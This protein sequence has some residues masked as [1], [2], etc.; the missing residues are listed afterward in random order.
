M[1]EI[2]RYEPPG[3]A[4]E[5]TGERWTSAAHGQIEIEH[6]H[7]Y[8]LARDWCRG[9]DVLDIA[10]GEGYGTALLAQV[11]RHAVGVEIDRP[12]LSHA[13]AQYRRPNLRYVAGD[14]CRLP[15]AAA[16]VDIAVSFETLEHLG[17]QEAFLAEI[18]R[19][20][21]PGGILLI[22]T[23]DRDVYSP[24]GS[25]PNV[26]H[27][28]ELSREEFAALLFR[29]FPHV[30]ICPQ[31]ALVGSAILPPDA[32]SPA[33]PPITY[34]RRGERH[35]ERSEGLPRALYLLAYASDRPIA[36][37]PGPSLYIH[38]L[39]IDHGAVELNGAGAESARSRLAD[40][41][42][43]RDAAAHA[44]E[45]ARTELA[46]TAAEAARL[47]VA[48]SH[49]EEEMWQR[50]GAAETMRAE[51]DRLHQLLAETEYQ[52]RHGAHEAAR[53]RAEIAELRHELEQAADAAEAG[54]AEMRAA[55]TAL[56]AARQVGRT[57][58]EALAASLPAAGPAAARR[59]WRQWLAQRW[60]RPRGI[61]AG[62]P[63]TL[64]PAR[65]GEVAPARL[66]R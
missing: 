57:A 24:L 43:E 64:P 42:R 58:L 54:A 38:S 19:V 29:H 66:S 52:L 9:K 48:L 36:A 25:S 2:F 39:D 30:A 22:S 32:G 20:L 37:P 23:P 17:E 11:A 3:T 31:R 50:A 59:G 13:A 51:I 10:C 53:L 34:E 49:A 35:L 46:E 60:S 61:A 6:L 28:R 33:G 1:G 12:T 44:A 55:E 21:R 41:V 8:I 7:R 15:M 65:A 26:Y 27:L 16:S 45:A 63:A 40:L 5:F 62:V 18:R 56:A 47:R 4:L 14:A